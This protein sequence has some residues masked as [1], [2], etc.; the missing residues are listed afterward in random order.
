VRRSIFRVAA[1]LV[2][3]PLWIFASE[4]AP[5][6]VHEGD[7]EHSDAIVHSHFESHH[8]IAHST[9]APEIEPGEQVIWLHASMVGAFS[10]HLDRPTSVAPGATD[11]I[12]GHRSW[13]VIAFDDGAPTHGPPRFS[14]GLKAPPAHPVSLI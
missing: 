7:A 11:S 1:A 6:H 10:F 12:V 9:G 2:V 8:V 4:V 3:L 5:T 14:I 13:S